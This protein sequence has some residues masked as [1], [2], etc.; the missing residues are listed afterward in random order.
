MR[1]C[2]RRRQRARLAGVTLIELMVVVAISAIL[3]AVGMPMMSSF[4]DRN[5]VATQ[6]NE[7]IADVALTRSE[8]IARRGRV[9]LC[10]SANPTVADPTCDGAAADWRSG[11]IVFVDNTAA[12]AAFQR[13][14]G[15]LLIRQYAPTGAQVALTAAP[16]LGGVTVTA[17]GTV[18]TLDGNPLS[19][20]GAGVEPLRM[21]F[22]GS[23]NANRRSLCIATTGRARTSTTFGS[24]S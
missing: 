20:L 6:V 4:I 22:T 3:L 14:A 8:A 1:S 7:L 21:D 17:D 16:A 11:W 9:V 13:D 19:S 12:G 23:E 24:C 5:R 10:R 15:E 18:W 2:I